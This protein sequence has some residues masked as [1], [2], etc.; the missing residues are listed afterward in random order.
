MLTPP[1][2]K[3][4]WRNR[5]STGFALLEPGDRLGAARLCLKAADY[6]NRYPAWRFIYLDEDQLDARGERRDPVFR[7]EF[8]PGIAARERTIW[9]IVA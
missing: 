3:T 8:D 9:A 4:Y 5:R 6:I 2:R 1:L 7:P